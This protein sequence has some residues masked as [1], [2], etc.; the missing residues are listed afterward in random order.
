MVGELTP[1][2]V[3]L[4]KAPPGGKILGGGPEH[5][6][7]LVMGFVVLPQL[8]IR[9]SERDVRREVGRMPLKSGL[10][11]RHGFVEAA[12]PAVFLGEGGDGD[13]GR[14]HLDPALQLFD[15]R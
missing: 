7:Q 15:A 12:R 8:E 6:L 2:M 11:S 5:V 14:V 3:D 4:R 9:A 1:A 13:G 10:A